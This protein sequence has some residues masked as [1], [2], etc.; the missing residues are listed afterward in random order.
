MRLAALTL[1]VLACGTPEPDAIFSDARPERR[2]EVV[3]VADAATDSILVFGG[4]DGPI[5]GQVPSAAYRDDTWLFS[6][7][8]GW[9]SVVTDTH[10]STRGRYVAT[11]D[12][13]TGRALLF[14]GRFRRAGQTGDYKLFADLW[15]FDPAAE[16][17]TRLAGGDDGPDPRYH[18]ALAYDPVAE[19]LYVWG[20]ATNPDPLIIAPAADLWSWKEGEGW[21]EIPTT[22]EAPSPRVFSGTVYD[23][24]RN[25]L[26]VFGGQVGD[27]QSQAYQDTYALDLATATWSRLHDGTGEAPSTRM[28]ASLLYDAP[29]DRYVLFAGHTDLGDANDVWAF[30]PT[31]ST[32]SVEWEGDQFTGNGLGCQKNPSEVPAD[33]VDQ[34]LTGPERRHRGM[35]ANLGSDLWIFGGMHSECSAYLD[36][37][38]RY[39]LTDG[40][41]TEVIEAQ[42]GESCLRRGDDCRCL[43]L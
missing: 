30:D 3:A 19:S 33:Y 32:W 9:R 29:R 36:D 15:A 2:S 27:F 37:T 7:T 13:T 4:N 38:W 31:A 18:A 12:P 6:P 40:G 25:R 10:P 28:H 23:S 34:D 5:V 42:S 16:A 39:S 41:W 43:C 1:F 17:W 21:T 14:G 22:G 8:T 24:Q 35:V 26:V 20:G 11:H